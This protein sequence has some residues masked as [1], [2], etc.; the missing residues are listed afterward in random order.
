MDLPVLCVVAVSGP[1]RVGG[2]RWAF[3]VIRQCLGGTG[4]GEDACHLF[5]SQDLNEF[6]DAG[7]VS[8]EANYIILP[9]FLCGQV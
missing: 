5:R 9:R 3:L 7:V 2:V 1:F 4:V 6:F 8:L